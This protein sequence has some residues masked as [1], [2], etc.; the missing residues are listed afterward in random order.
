MESNDK[1]FYDQLDLDPFTFSSPNTTGWNDLDLKN[2]LEN[3]IKSPNINNQQS[4]EQNNHLVEL[5][6]NEAEVFKPLPQN[7]SIQL[8]SNN[9]MTTALEQAWK[10]PLP[11]APLLQQKGNIISLYARKQGTLHERYSKWLAYLHA[12]QNMNNRNRETNSNAQNSTQPSYT[13]KHTSKQNKINKQ[14]T[15]TSKHKTTHPSNQALI[16]IIQQLNKQ[17][18]EKLQ[19]KR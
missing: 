7:G 11:N 16:H 2:L 6:V 10:Q 19:N 8:D 14:H 9:T 13:L 17:S 12:Q 3:T 1:L 5:F 18:M 4:L 15:M